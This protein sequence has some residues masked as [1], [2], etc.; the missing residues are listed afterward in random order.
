MTESTRLRW[1]GV[2][3]AHRSEGAGGDPLG[4]RRINGEDLNGRGR[5][6]CNGGDLLL[7]SAGILERIGAITHLFRV[8]K[9]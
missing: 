5:R 7:M 4:P 3:L 2:A 8:D 1:V 9:R 6:R